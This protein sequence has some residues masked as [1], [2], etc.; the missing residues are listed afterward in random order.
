[1]VKHRA[2]FIDLEVDYIVSFNTVSKKEKFCDLLKF[3]CDLLFTSS[4][5]MHH[6]KRRRV[7]V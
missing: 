2:I 3:L 6:L 1:M 5:L 4:S 7:A